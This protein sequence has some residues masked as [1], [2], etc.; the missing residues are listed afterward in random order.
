MRLPLFLRP[1]AWFLL[2][3]CQLHLQ[4]QI[5][6]TSIG[7]FPAGDVIPDVQLSAGGPVTRWSASNLVDRLS[8]NRTSGIISGAPVA[9]GT[10][11]ARISASRSG[12][13]TLQ[14]NVTVE[15]SPNAP[16]VSSP[17]SLPPATVGIFYG[18]VS[19][20]ATGGRSP[21][22]WSVRVIPPSG[23]G[24]FTHSINSL[25]QFSG[26]FSTSGNYVV[27]VTVAGSNTFPQS[28]TSNY[29]LVVQP[30]APVIVSPTTLPP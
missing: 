16:V 26:N 11:V 21:Y 15:V 23:S 22:A 25:G 1:A 29:T 24:P 9:P 18:P 2:A 14:G 6:P 19:F 8:L 27:R 17:A 13:P 4:A 12:L 3:T 5:S 28:S 7:P 20:S 10:Y 30:N